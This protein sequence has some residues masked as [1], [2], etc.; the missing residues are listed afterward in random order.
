MPFALTSAATSCG[1]AWASETTIP[2]LTS[3]SALATFSG[4]ILRS[5][6][7]ESA[8]TQIVLKPGVF[9]PGQ[10][11]E[12]ALGGRQHGF[13]PQAIVERG[14]DF[15]IGRFREMIREA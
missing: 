5:G 3:L 8:E 4:V 2:R 9:A 14:E 10:N 12:M 11:L 1:S 15:E 7:P 13:L 6:D